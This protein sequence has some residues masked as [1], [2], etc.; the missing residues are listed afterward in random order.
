MQTGTSVVKRQDY[1]GKHKDFDIA[2]QKQTWTSQVCSD[3]YLALTKITLYH[4][5]P[6]SVL[7]LQDYLTL[8][9]YI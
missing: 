7:D 5:R 4:T 9:C 2:S 8:N 6:I 3:F 1:F